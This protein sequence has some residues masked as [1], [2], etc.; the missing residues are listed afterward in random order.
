M[1][2]AAVLLLPPPAPAGMSPV[3]TLSDD[4]SECLPWCAIITPPHTQYK[5]RS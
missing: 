2:A 4:N 3:R 5:K 1:I